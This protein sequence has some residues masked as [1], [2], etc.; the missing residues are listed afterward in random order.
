MPTPASRRA[1]AENITNQPGPDQPGADQHGPNQSGPDQPGS[2]QRGADQPAPS[3]KKR[4]ARWGRRL[5]VLALFLV[6]LLGVVVGFAPQIA[7]LPT[8]Y[9]YGLSMAND[10]LEGN[11]AIDGLALS[12]G[13][14]I[15]VR[16]LRVTDPGGMQVVNVPRVTA[17]LGLWGLIRSYLNFQTIEI[18]SPDITIVLTP[19]NK[20]T[21][22]EAFS[23]KA[24]ATKTES[25][26]SLPELR[27][28][29]VLK[30]GTVR[31]VRAG[32]DEYVVRGINSDVTLATLSEIAGKL[33]AQLDKGPTLSADIAT[34]GLVT[35]GSFSA[36]GATGT[37][38]LGTDGPIDLKPLTA[39]LMPDA[40]LHGAVTIRV[41]GTFS[42]GNIQAMVEVTAAD[43]KS[44]SVV[45]VNP[46]DLALRG[47]ATITNDKIAARAELAGEAGTATAEVA[48]SFSETP[49]AID[50][51]R[52]VSAILQGESLALPEFVVSATASIDLAAVER[53]VPGVLE[54]R[55][56]QQIT[57]GR[58]EVASLR[59]TGG[60]TPSA[61]GAIEVKG[62]TVASDGTTI[63]AQPMTLDF[64]AAV[65][66]DRGLNVRRL[67]V[68]AAFAS[69]A[70]E[71]LPTD[72]NAQFEADLTKLQ[73]ELGQIID[74][75]VINMAGKLHGVANLTRASEDKFTFS[76][77]T[78]ARGLSATIDGKPITIN[79]AIVQKSGS[80]A[81]TGGKPGRVSAER[82]Q[83]D[84]DGQIVATG[85]GWYDL[86]SS[87]YGV[88]L[89]IN[90]ADLGFA[91]GKIAVLAGAEVGEVKGVLSGQVKA[92]KLAGDK[93]LTSSG[94][95][96]TAGLA[97]DGQVLSQQDAVASWSGA[98]VSADYRQVGV[99]KAHVQSDFAALNASNVH[100]DAANA[101]AISMNVDATADLQRV[102]TLVGRLA[103]MEK[104]PAVGGQLKLTGTAGASGGNVAVRGNGEIT[105]F[106]VGVGEMAVREDRVGLEFD[107]TIDPKAER[108]TL[109]RT[110][111][112]SKPFS[113]ELTGSV[114]QYASGA[115]LNLKG[116]YDAQWEP[117]TRLLHEL[118]PDTQ[119][120]VAVKGS[121]SSEITISG[122][123]SKPEVVPSYRGVSGATNVGWNGA[124]LYGVALG[125][126]LLAPKLA[127]GQ[128]QVPPAKVPAGGG[129]LLVAGTLDM[130]K[131][132]PTFVLA[133]QNRIIDNVQI[134]VIVAE[135]LLS[136]INPFFMQVTKIEGAMFLDTQDVYVPLG[137]KLRTEGR[138][139]GRLE[140]KQARLV[141]NGG[142]AELLNLVAITGEDVYIV[143]VSGFDFELR[144][145]RI[146]YNDL[147]M[148]FA[149]GAFD[150][151]F[152]GSV[153][154]DGSLELVVSIPISDKLL[155]RLGVT[156]P[157]VEYAKALA[158]S[159]VEVPL[160][161]TREKPR[162]DFSK[163]D[164]K[165]LMANVAKKAGEGLV[166]EGIRGLL[167]GEK[168]DDPNA[169]KKDDKKPKLPPIK[170]PGRG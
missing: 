57:G 142:F 122:P 38:K 129:Q 75:G 35:D 54:T 44:A 34:R 99:E 7:S 1:S 52:I 109:G 105:Q 10:M 81:L 106:I 146:Y 143:E 116:R 17:G 27:G 130:T 60:A 170:I 168:R 82:L 31:V 78:T 113:A 64:D 61:R 49:V 67:G 9:G 28:R 135:M 62:V 11:I 12:W 63:S 131:D 25:G 119:K 18:E 50:A 132:E 137:D 152:Y 94:Q 155:A 107:A 136:Y 68:R 103:K 90:K 85:S 160:S 4:K 21:I 154:L 121:S 151:K 104:P 15:E 144:Q 19:D 20:V 24:P 156:G 42:P 108:I 55:E 140:L 162:L 80:I 164:T 65:E 47:D 66:P 92:D 110:Q 93:P 165:A 126:A 112:S 145:G 70:A 127:D 56:G 134:N 46:I 26:G 84:V 91:T 22:A 58:L 87:G 6:V 83:V 124:D 76:L 100:W 33:S 163:V 169:P 128:V 167:G 13:G 30:D 73:N 45:N 149:G 53:A 153:G 79:Q 117:I 166:E 88:D 159:R 29:I 3:A 157:V 16:G 148:R 95:L 97:I 72:L 147:W 37:L 125:Q 51:R 5:G 40:G 23:P 14:P 48:Y 39:A 150:L 98:T 36:K 138:G 69:L 71:G 114:D 120:I 41:D 32:G 96:T 89:A 158:G 111:M 161:G 101:A 8:V 141:P 43:L 118:L 2:D 59:A 74:L 123:A 86:A 102:M 133:G 139:K 115:M 77:N